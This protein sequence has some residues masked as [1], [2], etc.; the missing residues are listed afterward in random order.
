M[1][2]DPV[3]AL[4]LDEAGLATPPDLAHPALGV[5]TSCQISTPRDIS[6]AQVPYLA[7]SAGVPTAK[8]TLVID[9]PALANHLHAAG[10]D[11]RA[12]CDDL[13]DERELAIPPLESLDETTLAG[14][15][16]VLL[17]LP[18]SLGML[19]DY[20]ERVA[21]FATPGVRLLAGGREKHLTRGMNDVLARSFGDVR[22]SRGRQKS[23]VLHA[24]DPTPGEFSWPHTTT[25]DDL[26]LVSHP[27]TFATDKLDGGTRLLLAA[28]AASPALAPPSDPAASPS[29]GP[30]ASPSSDPAASRSS[31]PA[32]RPS[33][34]PAHSPAPAPAHSPSFPRRRES[35]PADTTGDPRLRGDDREERDDR[36]KRAV[37][38]GCGTGI[39]AT[40]LARQGHDVLAV[41]VSRAAC[42][43]ARDTA[44]A[45]GVRIDVLR[46]DALHAPRASVDLVVCNPPFHRG[47]T[48]DST[49]GFDLIRGAI[50]ALAPGAEFW[51]V[52]NSHLPYLP[53][54]RAEIGSTQV[55]ARDRHY[56]VTRSIARG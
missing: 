5:D 24:G 9:D 11:V 31:D 55:V 36:G 17:R 27:G 20:A 56:T 23:R 21:A 29:S 13:R 43:S 40:T 42:A 25:L 32:H 22:A 10:H 53:F 16:L 1:H 46:A 45:N 33:S 2:L 26:T 6:V 4:L 44:A 14:V 41:D 48:K 38:L 7:V 3:S 37:D 28:L 52:F 39:L 35:P 19:E 18:K 12:Y 50:P 47:T 30:A 15:T 54:L 51:T 49:P 34:D 8:S